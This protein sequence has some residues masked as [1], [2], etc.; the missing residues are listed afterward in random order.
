MKAQQRSRIT[1]PLSLW[2]GT[3]FLV[4]LLS[5]FPDALRASWS[6]ILEPGLP[7]AAFI[8][9]FVLSAAL[10]G[11]VLGWLA[12]LILR[13]ILRSLGSGL[14][15]W[16]VAVLASAVLTLPQAL[17][18]VHYYIEGFTPFVARHEGVTH[19][20]A[21]LLVSLAVG[22]V[23]GTI[24]FAVARTLVTRRSGWVPAAMVLAAVVFAISSYQATHSWNLRRAL[25]NRT[26]TIGRVLA[27]ID[28]LWDFDGDHFSPAW[29]GGGD[30]DDGD[31][32]VHP[33]TVWAREHA[34]TPDYGP[35][36]QDPIE[37]LPQP[38]NILLI[39]DDTL[40]ADHLGCYGYPLGTS[41]AIDSLASRGVLFERCIV[42]QPKTSPSVASLM[43]GKPPGAH[44]VRLIGQKL[45][46]RH[47]TL[48]EIVAAL[49]Y[50]TCGVTKSG[51]VSTT[52]GFDQGFQR[53]I[54]ETSEVE[55]AA[56]DSALAW[57]EE[58]WLPT[59]E[60]RS[61]PGRPPFFLWM[62]YIDPHGPYNRPRPYDDTSLDEEEDTILGQRYPRSVLKWLIPPYQRLNTTRVAHY[63]AL[64]NG[65]ISSVDREMERLL[66]W[67]KARNLD[68]STLVIFSSDHG[69]SF[70][71]HD[72]YFEHGDVAYDDNAHVP[73]IL[74]LPGV[75]PEGRRVSTQ[76]NNIDVLSTITDL[77]DIPALPGPEGRSLL[78]LIL[79][80]TWRQPRP[81]HI[82]ANYIG[83]YSPRYFTNAMTDGRWKII[84][85][86][87]FHILELYDLQSDPW[88]LDNLWGRWN[89]DPSGG[90]W[91][92]AGVRLRSLLAQQMLAYKAGHRT[93]AAKETEM[94]EDLMEQLRSLGYIN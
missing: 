31:P 64:Y 36:H 13:P 25:F 77:L 35:T 20:P 16:I 14:W 45:R 78:G 81:V 73:L 19:M 53:F 12:G 8:A 17:L 56:T 55:S 48:A 49:G 2:A 91:R 66:Q 28:M 42:P 54:H 34:A 90:E 50:M 88:E 39:T 3:G 41:P 9:A 63:I 59:T 76:V 21:C 57:L 10:W 37:G 33:L 84:Y 46:D 32:D 58:T 93:E 22:I 6:Q 92:E 4:A 1:P 7:K 82:L 30:P 68:G 29:L 89:E 44:Y 72:F 24:S 61:E 83:R 15:I 27:K 80:G 11:G 52:F 43:T 67:L 79:G 87:E 40:R 75:F 65:E 23:L 85:I 18:F 94:S 74:S 71:E 5:L 70:T 38:L 69:E 86:P 62:H 47:L 26:T 60:F 51:V